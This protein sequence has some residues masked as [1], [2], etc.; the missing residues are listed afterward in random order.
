MTTEQ[1]GFS[2]ETLYQFERITDN[3]LSP[4]GQHIIYSV[5]RI[6]R[7]TEK[8]Y[9]DLWVVSPMVT[10]RRAVSRM[11]IGLTPHRAGRPTAIQSPFSNRKD[12]KQPQLYLLPFH[13]GEA[14]LLAELKGTISS[15]AWSPNGGSLVC[16]FRK[17][18]ADVLE[19][20]GR[21]A[22]TRT[23]RRRPPYQTWLLQSQRRWLFAAG[24]ESHLA[25]RCG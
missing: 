19:R 3:Q 24:K 16:G 11:A 22:K 4:D 17:A 20:Q 12:G 7:K 10:A 5:E 1:N 6:E 23:G 25:H 18:D 13:G 15:F 9:Q 2:A 21:Q 8:K 14:R